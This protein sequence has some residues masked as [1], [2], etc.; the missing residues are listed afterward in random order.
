MRKLFSVFLVFLLIVSTCS[1]YT[2][3]DETIVYITP[4][5]TKYHREDCSYTGSVRSMTIQAAEKSGYSPC[6]RCDPDR[7]TGEYTS[8]Y[9]RSSSNGSNSKKSSASSTSSQPSRAERNTNEKKQS[10]DGPGFTTLLKILLSF[11]SSIL[12]VPILLLL[13]LI[14]LC[15][16]SSKFMSWCSNRK[17]NEHRQ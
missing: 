1:A 8:G 5:G 3:P 4:T 6:S 17:K 15:I 12:M 2:V 14:P 7:R 13:L 10:S 11:V 9:E 16:A